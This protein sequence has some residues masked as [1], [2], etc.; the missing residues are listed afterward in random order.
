MQVGDI[1]VLLIIDQDQILFSKEVDY[2]GRTLPLIGTHLSY[3]Y[4]DT[5]ILYHVG[6]YHE[7]NGIQKPCAA[8]ISQEGLSLDFLE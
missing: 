4:G 7:E 1:P 8:R 5:A 3:M 2:N 6:A